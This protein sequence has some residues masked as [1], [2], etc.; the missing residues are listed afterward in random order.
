MSLL[1]TPNPKQLV[2]HLAP[3]SIVSNISP[4]MTNVPRVRAAVPAIAANISSQILRTPAVHAIPRVRTRQLPFV[5]V[6]IALVRISVAA[7]L[8]NV[9]PVLPDV[10]SILVNVA[11]LRRL[12][13]CLRPCADGKKAHY[14]NCEEGMSHHVTDVHVVSP[15][16]DE[17]S[18]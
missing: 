6:D 8:T 17:I 18:Y 7:V 3:A 13:R 11:L 12:D 14:S 16:A 4:I 2:W 10:L 15:Y 9:A 5:A 1:F